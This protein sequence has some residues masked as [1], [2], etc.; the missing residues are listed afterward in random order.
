MFHDL[1]YLRQRTIPRSD[2]FIPGLQIGLDQ[3]RRG[4]VIG[5]AYVCG[6]TV[7]AGTGTSVRD[8]KTYA[9][10]H[11]HRLART[12]EGLCDFSIVRISPALLDSQNLNILFAEAFV[13]I[14][15]K[16]KPQKAY[17]DS[18]W[19]DPQKLA[20]F[21]RA[22][23][24]CPCLVVEHKADSKYP[25]VSAASILCKHLAQVQ[26]DRLKQ[27]IGDF[28]S[29]YPADPRTRAYLAVNPDCAYRRKKWKLS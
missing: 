16:M 18:A 14:L 15:N 4:S 8:S 12:L 5:A 3:C 20:A 29:G 24:S 19:S 17:V 22:R 26:M 2:D 27:L 25:A 11:L 23:T 10:P 7:P 13:Q 28:G 6:S 1:Q 21:L 9:L